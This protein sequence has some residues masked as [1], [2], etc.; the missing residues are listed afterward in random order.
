VEELCK[1]HNVM[2]GSILEQ[3]ND[4]AF[5]KIENSVIDDDGEFIYVSTDYKNKLI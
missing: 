2:M 4:Y 3:I 5:E 1:K